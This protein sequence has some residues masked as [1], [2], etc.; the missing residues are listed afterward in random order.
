VLNLI[1]VLYACSVIL[2]GLLTDLQLEAILYACDQH[3]RMLPCDKTKGEVPIRAGFFMGDGPGVGKG[4]Q[5]AGIVLENF[6]RGRKKAV[7][8][9]VGPDLLEDARRDL[10]DIGAGAIPVHDLKNHKVSKKLSQVK[11]CADGVLFS[12][13]TL[14]ALGIKAKV[15]D[16]GDGLDDK[17]RVRQIVEW[18]GPEFDGVI[19]FDEAHKA[20]NMTMKGPSENK[21]GSKRARKNKNEVELNTLAEDQDVSE[22]VQAEATGTASAQAV[23]ML[24]KLLPNA[25]V[26]YV[27]ATGASEPEHLLYASRLGLWGTGTAFA[28]PSD[29]A[30]EIN[31]GGP[32]AMELL[33]MQMK[34]SGKYLARALSFKGATFEV[35]D[36]ELSKQFED[37]YDASVEL[38]TD[39]VQSFTSGFKKHDKNVKSEEGKAMKKKIT[40]VTRQMWGAHQRFFGQLLMAAKVDETVR[41]TQ[42]AVDEGK[43]VVIGLQNTGEA[44][45]TDEEMGDNGCSAADHILRNLLLKNGQEFIEQDKVSELLKQ[46]DALKLPINPL[47]GTYC[48]SNLPLLTKAQIMSVLTKLTFYSSTVVT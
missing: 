18:C 26:V 27:S 35:V 7:W 43:C 37:M 22:A 20:K 3:E 39:L 38:W 9:S 4:R 13:Y 45:L 12:T 6:L 21:E 16:A 46:L 14:L 25:R 23:I 11:E 41:L 34:Q 47:D 10:R 15:G 5:I 42:E 44:G 2:G 29:F 19:A 32:V 33:A 30:K 48:N 36:V 8:I 24:Q 17:S 1:F 31:E 28:D 40:S